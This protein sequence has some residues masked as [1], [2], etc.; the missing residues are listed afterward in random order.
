MGVTD[1]SG[2]INDPLDQLSANVGIPKLRADIEPFHLAGLFVN[3][4]QSN[5]ACRRSIAEGQI[6]PSPG[7]TVFLIQMGQFL[8]V[9]LE[10]QI[11]PE[12]AVARNEQLC[13]FGK[14][15]ADFLGIPVCGENG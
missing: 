13:L 14:Q 6:Q 4:P 8:V 2:V 10:G 9:V 1:L 7:L 3:F 5:T 12:G 11:V 15:L